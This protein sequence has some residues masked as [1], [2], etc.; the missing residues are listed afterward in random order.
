MA[1]KA[2]S[3]DSKRAAPSRKA[4]RKTAGAHGEAPRPSPAAKVR[5]LIQM[6]EAIELL[7]TSRSTFYRWVRTGKIKG[8]K[9]GRQWRFYRE[10]IERFLKGEG[11]RIELAADIRPL[12]RKLSERVKELG[13]RE[14]S[15]P[16]ATE[17]QRAVHL[18]IYLGVLMRASDIHIAP[19]VKEKLDGAVAVL[20]YRVD[21]MLYPVAEIDMRLFPA[22]VEQWKSMA[23]CNVQESAKP[24]DGRIM[25]EVAEKRLDIRVSFL[26]A[27]LGES[28]TL[29]IL[30][31]DVVGLLNFDR[32]AYAPRDKEK[33]LGAIEAR[34]GLVIIAGP[35]GC[36][37]TTALY[38]CL[39]HLAGPSRKTMTV[40]DPV[41]VLLP[42]VVQSPLNP[43]QG[44][45]FPIAV[46]G[47]LRSDPDIMMIGE[48]RDAQTLAM[49]QQCALTGH[50]VLTTLHADESARALT[51][52]VQMGESPFVIADATK[53]V[54][55]QRLVR[56]LCPACAVPQTPTRSHLER[57]EELA[58]AGGL[59]WDAI[60]KKFR[61]PKGCTKCSGTGFRGR[62]AIA[63]ALEV[64]PEIGSALMR[65]ASVEDLRNIA[66]GQGMTT[67][68]ADGIRR[69]AA[70]E[71]TLGEVQRVLALR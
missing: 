44:V 8:M 11:P 1:R 26:P 53:L 2:T 43:G 59:D 20:R 18:T 3:G 12:V 45:T 61:A 5:E 27:S 33:L 34:W 56:K 15:Q 23:A 63:E 28:V 38:A 6:D 52:M 29:R 68:A 54:V 14:I 64:T 39:N 21:G 57:A 17:V 55:A 49:A 35:T 19:H 66:V 41:E 69:A 4:G 62:N 9:L 40:E 13:G 22:I 24:Q 70:G 71:T 50:N 51:R 7:K 32:F 58:R 65:D 46:R 67:M 36:G 48:L 37:K 60:P 47:M 31:R 10:D 16:E 30:D 25:V 42:W